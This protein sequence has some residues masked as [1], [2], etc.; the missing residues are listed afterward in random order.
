[1]Q[2]L[3]GFRLSPQQK[4]LWFLQQDSVAY[5]VQAAIRIEGNVK[6]EIL[7]Q[8]L[9]QVVDRHESLRTTF[10]RQPGIKIPIQVIA[11]SGS[12][13]GNQANLKELNF[14]E[15]SAY[16]EQLFQEAGNFNFKSKPESILHSSLLTLSDNQHILL[17]TLPALCAD[18]WTLKN[19]LKEIGQTYQAYFN[20]ENLPDEEP[21]Q[22]IQ[23]SEWQNEILEDEDAETGKAYWRNQTFPN[24][25]LP[26]EAQPRSSERFEPEVCTIKIYP[27]VAAKLDAIATSYKTSLSEV[28]F[29]CWYTL[30]WRFTGQ[31]N[32]AVSTVYSGRKYEELHEILGLLAKWLPVRCSLQNNLKLSEVLSQVGETLREVDQWQDYFVGE[33]IIDS[34]NDTVNFQIGRAV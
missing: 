26:F 1:M 9:E 7:K 10:H 12:L 27:D 25:A 34:V 8:T 11:E 13:S 32:I 2:T 30:L 3:E 29:A 5:R 17:I 23:F 20:G 24:L 14:Q 19:L 33:K 4:R 31:S 6:I 21:V 15:Q 16:I 18:S 28:L 22:Y